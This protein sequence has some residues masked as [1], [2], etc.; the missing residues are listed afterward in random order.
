MAVAANAPYSGVGFT[1][2]WYSLGNSQ[3]PRKY[4][5]RMIPRLCNIGGQAN[6]KFK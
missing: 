1:A 3:F 5:S 2:L 6:D 4:I